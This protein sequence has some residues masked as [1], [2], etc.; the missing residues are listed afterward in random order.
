MSSFSPISG[1]GIISSLP[2][3][4]SVSP[5]L[6]FTNASNLGIYLTSSNTTGFTTGLGT[7]A[8][9]VGDLTI[10]NTDP[11]SPAL[12]KTNSRFYPAS[13]VG[14]I[15]SCGMYILV[16]H[17]SSDHTIGIYGEVDTGQSFWGGGFTK[18]ITRGMGDAHYVAVLV[19][20]SLVQQAILALFLFGFC[21]TG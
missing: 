8:M 10:T 5:S 16:H 4:S 9:E 1:S 18:C 19:Q 12:V 3:G 14:G 13:I 17:S 20:F 21:D 15:E 6:N 11:I 2:D 7:V